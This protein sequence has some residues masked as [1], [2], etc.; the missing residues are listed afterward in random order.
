MNK[1]IEVKI[2]ITK[3]DLL[4][5]SKWLKVNARFT[6]DMSQT[7]YYL[8]NPKA[9]FFYSSEWRGKDCDNY[10]RIRK[11]SKK[12]FLCLKYVHR[13]EKGQCLYCDEYEVVIDNAEDTL[14]LMKAAGFVDITILKKQRETYLYDIFEIAID[15]VSDL[16]VFV[17]VELKK[18]VINY[19]VGHQLIYDLL[20]TIG[21][22]KFK[23]QPQGY[24]HQLWNPDLDLSREI[25]L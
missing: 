24:V 17:E 16:G 14:Q 20:R 9:P 22:T 23:L 5:L 4:K 8:N 21:L 11:T 7:D 1:E 2:Q 18:E 12:S 15:T 25:C 3:N 13:G 19:E 6:G 10:L